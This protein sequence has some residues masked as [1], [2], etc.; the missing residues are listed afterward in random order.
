[1]TSAVRRG[2]LQA[3]RDQ[4]RARRHVDDAS[5]AWKEQERGARETSRSH[6]SVI[7]ANSSQWVASADETKGDERRMRRSKQ[8]GD[9]GRRGHRPDQLSRRHA[10]G[11]RRPAAAVVAIAL[12]IR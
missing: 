1:M 6:T 2:D 4:H 5:Y 8:R 10:D 7:A 3:E 12:I 9:P 11:R